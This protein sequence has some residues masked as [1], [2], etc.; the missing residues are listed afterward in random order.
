VPPLPP[1]VEGETLRERVDRH[2]GEGTCGAGCHGG[3]I[4]PL[5][6]AFENYGPMGQWQTMDAGKP[7]NAA[8]EFKFQDGVKP[9]DGAVELAQVMADSPDAHRCYVAHLLEYGYA[10]GPQKA[11]D[12]LIQ[13][14]A[15]A[16]QAGTL[17]IKQMILELT[18]SEAF[19]YRAPVE[20]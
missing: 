4:N 14:V 17:T 8:A 7:V 2:T 15:G 12:A 11:D 19:L 13:K 16:S 5:G 9:Y 6:F 10:R 18:Q 3:M 1:P 20:G